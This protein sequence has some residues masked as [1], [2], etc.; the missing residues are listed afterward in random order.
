MSNVRINTQ[1]KFNHLPKIATGMHAR[2]A[3]FVAKAAFDIQAHAQE[4]A[5]VDT[6]VLKAS[7]QARQIG[8]LHWQVTV[9]AHYGIYQEYG[10]RFMPAHPFL[11]PAIEQVRPMF[12]LAMRKVVL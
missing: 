12:L 10:T 5:P 9:G 1:V 11:N 3:S 4:R 8:P 7:I 6:G 2:A